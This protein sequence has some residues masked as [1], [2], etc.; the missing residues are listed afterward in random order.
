[1]FIRGNTAFIFII[2]TTSIKSFFIFNN[3]FIV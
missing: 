1:M 3:L 2:I